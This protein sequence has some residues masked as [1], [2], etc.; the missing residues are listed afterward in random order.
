MLRSNIKDW[1]KRSPET[2]K[3]ERQILRFVQKA[4]DGITFTDLLQELDP[5]LYKKMA[6]KRNLLARSLARLVNEN[7]ITKEEQENKVLYRAT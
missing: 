6:R 2:E 3:A 5:D 7:K 4:K 1:R